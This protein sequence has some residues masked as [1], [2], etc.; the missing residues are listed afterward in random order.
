[1]KA[2]ED[3]RMANMAIQFEDHRLKLEEEKKKNPNF[4]EE[5][6]APK[7]MKVWHVPVNLQFSKMNY[8]KESP[9]T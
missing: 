4:K 6:K 3:I 9:T 5:V 7:P 1:M 8:F 2:L